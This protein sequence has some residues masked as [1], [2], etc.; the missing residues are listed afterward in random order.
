MLQSHGRLR[1]TK[2]PRGRGSQSTPPSAGA[3]GTRVRIHGRITGVVQGVGFRFFV[4]GYAMAHD[5]AGFVRNL[6]GGGVEFAVEG[7][8]E[9]VDAVVDAVRRGPPGS[10]VDK[11]DLMW[12]PL[13]GEAGFSIRGEADG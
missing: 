1:G 2:L 5:L 4:R 12:Q 6:R 3:N 8:R 9:D 11:V 7:R 13:V 10:R